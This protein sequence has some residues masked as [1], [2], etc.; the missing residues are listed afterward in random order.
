MYS[1]LGT[2]Q[3]KS[4]NCPVQQLPTCRLSLT[5]C[6]YNADLDANPITRYEQIPDDVYRILT[7]TVHASI[8]KKKT[9]DE[10]ET[11]EKFR[12]LKCT[13]DTLSKAIRL[14]LHFLRATWSL[15]VAVQ[16]IKFRMN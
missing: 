5:L 11:G 3:A 8:K 13:C 4:E 1:S 9:D 12:P 15:R 16:R 2:K 14:L 6:A 10:M 7:T